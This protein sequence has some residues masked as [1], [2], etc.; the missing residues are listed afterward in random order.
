MAV[1]FFDFF[2]L[3]G[4]LDLR[5]RLGLRGGCFHGGGLTRPKVKFDL[6]YDKPI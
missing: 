3:S 2:K 6:A 5:E 1:T 4:D